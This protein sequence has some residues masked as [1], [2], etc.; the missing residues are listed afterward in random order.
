[1]THRPTPEHALQ[2]D[3]AV[4]FYADALESLQDAGVRLLVG[5]AYAFHRYS[6]IARHTKDFDIFVHP[7]DFDRALDVLRGRGYRTEV[8]FPHWLGKAWSGEAFMDIIFNSGNGV[9]L[10]DDEWFAQGPEATVLGVP[11]KLCPVEEMIWSKSFV[12]ERERCDAADVAHLLRQCA[13]WLDWD[14]LVRRFGPHWR[15]LLA[16]V[17]LFGFVYPGERA[18]VPPRVVTILTE[19]LLAEAAQPGDPH[20]C[21]G[22][23]LSRS[24]YLTDLQRW[25]YEDGRVFPRGTMTP[26]DI[27]RWTAAIDEH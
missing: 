15:V 5:G 19:R 13:D 8:P 3:T 14:R 26:E 20:V 22:P 25:D 10:V 11:V 1:M 9:V 7:R 2:D 16:H 12:I 17:V 4:S 6:G 27:A 24:Q 18:R 23:L 21:N